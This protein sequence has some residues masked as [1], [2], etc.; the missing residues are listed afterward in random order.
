MIFIASLVLLLIIKLRFPKGK[1]YSPD[2]FC[3]RGIDVYQ[4][5]IIII[6]F[7][8]WDKENYSSR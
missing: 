1:K 3:Y 8:T 7:V 2:T 6:K 4:Q 5:V